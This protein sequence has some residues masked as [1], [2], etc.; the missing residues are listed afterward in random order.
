MK[1][2]GGGDGFF[3]V[4]ESAG[5]GV[6]CAMGI[7]RDFAGRRREKFVPQIRIGVHEADALSHGNDF[8]GLGVHEA[9]RIAGY[10]GAGEVLAS[11]ATVAAAGVTAAAPVQ[12][13]ELKGLSAKVALRSI[14]WQ[15]GAGEG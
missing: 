10:A 3:A 7:Q 1:Q 14:L 12:E 13:V 2:R 5:D 11:L 8:A 4:F 6:S 15:A 9:A